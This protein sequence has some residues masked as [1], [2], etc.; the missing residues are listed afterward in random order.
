MEKHDY[1]N[2]ARMLEVGTGLRPGNAQARAKL[3]WCYEQT[4]RPGDAVN[5]Y[6]RAVEIAPYDES[7]AFAK[8]RLE[9]LNIRMRKK[10]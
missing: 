5:S 8:Q 2:G 6:R 7:T 3:G 10:R 9:F 4:G 1:Q